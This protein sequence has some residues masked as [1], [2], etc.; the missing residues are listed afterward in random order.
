MEDLE[1]NPNRRSNKFV[2]PEKKGFFSKMGEKI[3]SVFD[4][5][6]SK[7]EKE[8]KVIYNISSM[9][10]NNMNSK[11][12]SRSTYEHEVDTNI[13]SI[14]FEFLKDKVAFATGDPISCKCEAILNQ[15]SLIEKIEN[16]AKFLWLCEFCGEKNEIFIEK[17]EIPTTDC[18]DYFYQSVNQIKG[19]YNYNDEQTLI[20][21]FDI[22]GSMCVSSPVTG[23]HK[24]K[25]NSLEKNYKELM[26]FSDGSNQYFGSGNSNVTYV[27]RLQ[28]LQAAIE[29]NLT[30]L[31]K[32][33]PNRK[34]GFVTFNNEV[35]GYGDGT[36]GQVKINGNNLNEFDTI[37]EIAQNSQEIISVPLKDAH[38]YLLKQL[39]SLEETG[40]TALGPAILFSIN[41]IK[42]VSAGSRIILC[43]DGIS[44]MG[45]GSMDG[46][47]SAEEIQ[48]LKDFYLNLGLIAKEK[49]VIIDLLT[50][51]DEQS[52][53]EILMGMID[54]TGGEIIRVKCTDILEQFS[55]LLTNEIVATNV[56]IKVKLHKL[57]NFRNE[58]PLYIKNDGS[59]LLKDIGN[60]T[61]ES[62]L[63]VEYSFKK[64]D[65]IVKYE[66][67]DIENLKPVPFQ[68]IID[69]TNKN[70]DRCIR[71][72]S[73]NQIISSEK[74]VIQSKANFEIISTN[75]IQ[76]TSK[77]AE[78]GQYR[79]A[80][81]HALA[82]K[83]M[84]KNNAEYNEEA[85]N[86][87]KIFNN[88]MKD[89]NNNMQEYQYNEIVSQNVNDQSGRK[90]EM[91]ET[92][93][94]SDKLSQ[95]IFSSKNMNSKKSTNSY[96]ISKSKK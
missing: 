17:E 89:F 79:E 14:K 80:Q 48:V 69:Y 1:E 18:I 70:G 58:D 43:T 24:L 41:L 31:L 96:M 35:I 30:I 33:A 5:S 90:K 6:K 84:M 53:I 26:A 7:P 13:F 51:E 16:S 15:H 71:V 11:I 40:Q 2:K 52:N 36:K 86:N 12:K 60:V 50:F 66:D 78:N 32:S 42:G 9:L 37:K 76:K 34:V 93:L 81:S 88:N 38:D 27:S 62:E 92:S 20:F 68:S 65:E 67:I 63:F 22:S 64:S 77:L 73:K 54:Q 74:D 8:K 44:N 94:K 29:S 49:G 91:K 47:F 83:K 75:A 55:N 21:C 85:N 61:K 95:Q 28:C 59:V 25:G 39:Y 72:L 87:Y 3:K 57:M 82:W 46:K 10:M 19:N 56:K 23:K 45:V 4:S